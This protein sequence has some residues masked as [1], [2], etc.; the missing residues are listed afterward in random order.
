MRGCMRGWV[1]GLVTICAIGLVRCWI[2]QCFKFIS[3][4]LGEKL[5]EILDLCE[6]LLEVLCEWLCLRL[7]NEKS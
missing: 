1:R 2:H 3:G 6:N 5:V 7:K 4:N